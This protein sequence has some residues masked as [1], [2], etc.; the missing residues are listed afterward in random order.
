M[1]LAVNIKNDIEAALAFPGPYLYVAVVIIA[2][3]G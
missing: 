3:F 2:T 1:I